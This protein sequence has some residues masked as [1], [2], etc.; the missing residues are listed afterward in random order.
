MFKVRYWF[1]APIVFWPSGTRITWHDE[2]YP[3]EEEARLVA[4][5]VINRRLEVAPGYFLPMSNVG[6]VQVIQLE[7]K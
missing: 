7:A 6:V 4:T 2:S 5:S 1:I 3:S